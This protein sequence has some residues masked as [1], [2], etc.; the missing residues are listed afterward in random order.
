MSFNALVPAIFGIIGLFVAH[1]IYKKVREYPEGEALVA[2]IAEQ[3]HLGAMVFMRREY[4]MLFWFC[5]VLFLVLLFAPGLG[6]N[7]AISFVV[8]AL[9]SAGAGYI[10]MSTAT[11]ANVRT[12]TAAHTKGPAEALTVA[13]FG[14]SIM[15]LAVAS[16]GL[17]GL[18]T[19]YLFFGGDPETAHAIH[20]FGMGASS[21]ALFSRVGGGIYTKSADVGAD[22]VGKVEAGIPE[23][24]P[25]NPG[26]IADNVG[27]NVGDVAGMGSD[28]FESYCGAMIATIAMAST[29]AADMLVELGA[30]QS[31]MFLPLALAST[32]LVCSIIGIY[33]V[34]HFSDRSPE[35]ALRI[36]TI[37]ATVIFIAASFLVIKLVGVAGS[38]WAAVL[39]GALGGIVIGLVTEYF[40]AGAPVRHIAKQ[41]ETGP[42]TVIIAGLSVGMRSVAIPLLTIC[43]II[44]VS[45]TMAGLYGVGI[46]AVGMLAT[47]GITMAIDAY[48]PVADNAGGIAE[49]G[50][51]GRETR[52][53][54]DSLDELGNTTAAIGKGFAIGAAALAALAIISAF[55]ETVAH[56]VPGFTL[57]LGNPDVLVGLFMGG[58]MPFMIAALTM[59]AV[60][61]AA[62]EM[63]N[64]IRRQFREISGLLE[65]KAKP[66]TARCVDIAT[67]AALKKMVPPG[68][69]AVAAPWIVGLG[70]GPEALGG[71]LAGALLGCV[72]LA[73]TM[74]NAG[75]AWDN[76]KKYVEKGNYGGKGS[77]THK[78]AVVGDTV[79]DPFKDTS[80]PSMN[81]LINVMAIV[82]LVIAPLL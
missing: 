50:G 46:A 18:G 5:L 10:G 26:V 81:I 43:A 80:G 8:G 61:D 62:F 70:I 11:R 57:E 27:D 45:S 75:G 59:E 52:A 74:A 14:G 72:L 49:M 21:V 40:T 44:A 39:F 68:V 19:L 54:T 16:L 53:I 23:D 79:G 7:T 32:G 38:V 12:T 17:L 36:G 78:A 42:A 47:V 2:E 28:I 56:H 82:S 65:G 64:E 66:D 48:G 60:G 55:V 3:I 67:T 15:G 20:G 58:I 4:K 29:M 1:L 6:F 13:F 35:V 34:R 69:L 24:D 51:L 73:L 30:R 77:D 71:L 76:A 41:G 63:I 31:L 22:L 9:A 25:R 37:G 33:S